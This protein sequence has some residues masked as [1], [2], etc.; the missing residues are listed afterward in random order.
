MRRFL[1]LFSSAMLASLLVSPASAKFKRLEL[2]EGDVIE[3]RAGRDAATE[4]DFARLEI[5]PTAEHLELRIETYTPW[6]EIPDPHEARI[7]VKVT[8]AGA[9]K[10]L[11]NLYG[12]YLEEDG[13]LSVKSD[14]ITGTNLYDGKKKAWKGNPELVEASLDGTS[15]TVVIPWSDLPAEHIWLQ[16]CAH[17][18]IERDEDDED[19][20]SG[21]FVGGAANPV[22]S[23]Y[24]PNYK[25]AA[26]AQRPTS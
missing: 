5:V 19:E 22:P 8:R 24:V 18:E 6:V 9:K 1:I 3:D 21:K 14:Y 20:S 15:V 17:H 25:E 11:P 10:F 4:L 12:L 2:V 13:S 23:D 7:A 26:A 16:V